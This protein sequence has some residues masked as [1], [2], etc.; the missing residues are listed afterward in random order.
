MPEAIEITGG[1]YEHTLG[2]AR[3]CDGIDIR[4]ATAPL[5][6]VFFRMLT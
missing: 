5:R 1:D 3:I 2:L 4:Y 6:D